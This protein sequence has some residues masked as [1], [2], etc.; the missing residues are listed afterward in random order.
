MKN[1]TTQ[2][3]VS[4]KFTDMFIHFAYLP[5]ETKLSRSLNIRKS[6][7]VL[8]FSSFLTNIFFITNAH[9]TSSRRQLLDD[10]QVVSL[11]GTPTIRITFNRP[12]RYVQHTPRTSGR[13]LQIRVRP[14]IGKLQED[15]LPHRE[16]IPVTATREV[17]LK[18]FTFDVFVG[19]DSVL[20]LQFKQNVAYEVTPGKDLRSIHIAVHNPASVAAGQAL[21]VAQAAPAMKATEAA[22]KSPLTSTITPEGKSDLNDPT[23]QWLQRGKE[24]LI[25]KDYP[26]AV[27]Y[28]FKVL[29]SPSTQ[30]HQEALEL[31]GV[32]RERSGQ[33]DLARLTY[34]KYLSLYPEGEGAARV[35][36]R[37]S[38]IVTVTKPIETAP[39]PV[40]RKKKGQWDFYG[41]FSQIFFRD[42]TVSDSK[43]ERVNQSHLLNNLELTTRYRD[44]RYQFRTQF[45]GRIRNNIEESFSAN[46]W[47]INN[48]FIEGSDSKTGL[49]ARIG[50]QTTSTGGVLGRFDGAVIGYRFHPKWQF[51]AVGGF[52]FESFDT[53]KVDTDRNL[54]GFTLEWG[55]FY[56]YWAGN[57]FFINQEVD[58]V[59]DRRAIGTEIRYQHPKTPFVV[60]V[61]YDI[62][63]TS[64]NLAQLVGNWFMDNGATLTYRFD[65]RK[66]PVLT[67]NNALTGQTVD[68]IHELLKQR[69]TND[70][71]DLAQSN[72]FEIK[73]MFLDL[74]WPFTENFRASGTFSLTNTSNLRPFKQQPTLRASDLEFSYAAQFIA[75]NLVM[76]G[77][78]NLLRL[79]FINNSNANSYAL[80]IDNRYPITPS[81]RIDPRLLIDYIANV[82]DSPNELRIRPAVRFN[83][84]VFDQFHQLAAKAKVIDQLVFEVE[85]GFEWSNLPRFEADGETLGYYISAGYRLSF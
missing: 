1:E 58:S 23:R 61:D 17:P 5:E 21:P 60:L 45:D 9:A 85:T 8:L 42:A 65:Y 11:N 55:P 37:L 54:Y 83:F 64:L 50:R 34:E 41:G 66:T 22:E 82:N 46:R 25:K 52:P 44:D 32:A 18:D 43:G 7:F 53:N 68:S 27:E 3:I 73:Q 81:F 79:R 49:S 36:Q 10:M 24:A 39:A 80:T 29:R 75:T 57:V 67:T 6:I 35:R 77:D 48:L 26:T 15:I 13:T 63:F 30:Y 74:S 84:S 47:K 20:T 51:L 12:M 72:A 4:P 14:I 33:P 56:K 19:R 76:K 31:L 28:F 16:S 38:A 2:K 69:S 71:Q 70:V 40:A 59:T 62:H 78:V